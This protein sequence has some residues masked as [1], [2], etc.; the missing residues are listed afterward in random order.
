MEK[1]GFP[2]FAFDRLFTVIQKILLR[3]KP[4]NLPSVESDSITLFLTFECIRR[5]SGAE[6]GVE[7]CVSFSAYS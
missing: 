2:V 1:N 6:W 5:W 3:V 7:F 4:N